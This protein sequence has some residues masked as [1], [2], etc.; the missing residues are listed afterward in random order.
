M[1]R[2]M[3]DGHRARPLHE[4]ATPSLWR[5]VSQYT[6]TTPYAKLPQCSYLMHEIDWVENF[7]EEYVNFF[8]SG[9]AVS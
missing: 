8:E 5:Q 4:T 3:H 7:V 2:P 6:R 1:R 9:V